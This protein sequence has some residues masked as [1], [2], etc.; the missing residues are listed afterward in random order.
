[1]MD[2]DIPLLQ[3]YYFILECNSMISMGD[4]VGCMSSS[5]FKILFMSA[6]LFTIFNLIQS[7]ERPPV[8]SRCLL[9]NVYMFLF[10]ENTFFLMPSN[11]AA[12][13]FTL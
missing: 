12:P 13:L 10:L 5:L 8:S 2:V 7:L 1:M 3:V 4:G 11:A 6:S 9:E